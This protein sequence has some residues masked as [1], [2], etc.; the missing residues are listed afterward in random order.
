MGGESWYHQRSLS[1][2]PGSQGWA[3]RPSAIHA[4]LYM[5]I[6]FYEKM[7]RIYFSKPLR[8][9]VSIFLSC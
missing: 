8:L 2:I 1:H 5:F 3:C 7:K 6:L 4:A 9:F